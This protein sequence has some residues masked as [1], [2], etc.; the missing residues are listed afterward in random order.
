MGWQR[1]PTA[2]RAAVPP[3][4]SKPS[5]SSTSPTLPALNCRAATAG[6]NNANEKKDA[7]QLCREEIAGGCDPIRTRRLDPGYG[8][9]TSPKPA[10][11]TIAN[12][13][14]SNWN[15]GR[16][17]IG[18]GGRLRWNPQSDGLMVVRCS[19]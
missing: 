17:Q 10:H 9:M 15:G 18:T 6:I 19:L 11:E 8:A 7:S 5:S 12:W 14:P 2:C 1:F 13:P 16:D 3:R 4:H